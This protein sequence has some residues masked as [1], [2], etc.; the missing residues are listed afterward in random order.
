[1]K[2]P[3]PIG[4]AIALL[5]LAALFGAIERL[6]PAIPGVSIWRRHR[7]LDF[8][9]WFFT[10]IVTKTISTVAVLLAVVIASLSVSGEL[11]DRMSS[12]WFTRQ[13]VL[14]QFLAIL[15]VSDFLAYASHRLFHRRPLWKFHA[16]HHS[17]EELDWLSAT[18][19][20]PVNEIGARVFQVVPLFLLG[21]RGEAIAAAI[22]FLT[23]YAIFLHA[24]VPWSFG[25][26]RFVIASPRFHR[27]H[28]TSESEGLDKNFSGLFPWIDLIFGTFYMPPGLEPRHF[29]VS[30]A[31]PRTFGGQLAYPFRR[32]AGTSPV[33]AVSRQ[34]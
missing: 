7:R 30:D 5:V 29:G 15:I 19:L 20:H 2:A 24:N 27:W 17:S 3:N 1:M 26:L 34:T 31:V 13:S 9:Y 25:P 18:R 21:F 28:H 6:W 10:P 16:V 4:L 22:P 8:I 14:V 23:L 11:P 33:T 32:S 12:T